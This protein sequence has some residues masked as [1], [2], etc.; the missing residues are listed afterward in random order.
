MD[1]RAARYIDKWVGLAICAVLFYY[2]RVIGW[3]RGHPV[4]RR[5][6][7]TPPPLENASPVRVRRVLCVKF[8]GLGNIVMLLPVI[9]AMKRRHPDAEIDFLTLE[10]NCTLLE[11]SPVVSHV[12]TLSVSGLVPLILSTL[13]VVPA[14]RQRGYDAVVDFEQFAKIS[15][16]LAFLSGAKQ[17]IGF[18][19]DGQR[20]EGLF[21]TRVVYTDSEHMAHIFHRL[22]R[23]LDVPPELPHAEI[24]L[25]DAEEAV[26]AD[27]IRAFGT[28]RP[29]VAMHV[30]CGPNFYRVPLKRWEPSS[31]AAVADGLI[32]RYG[33][34]VVLTGAGA[35]ERELIAEV[36]GLMRH[37]AVD[38][39]NRFSVPELMAFLRQSTFLVANDT[40]LVHLAAAMGTPCVAMFG[41]TAPLHYGPGGPIDLV[42]YRD[43]YCSPCLTNYN[44]KISRCV[45]PVCMRGITPADVLA[46]IDAHYLGRDATHGARVRGRIATSD[47][48]AAAT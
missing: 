37:D 2:A 12:H 33:A 42:F 1:L 32:E 34:V 35:E 41:P 4:P 18:N 39:C 40:A 43:L 28:G 36:R 25:T 5:R 44:L 30:G 21:T 9:Q 8:Y 14:L 31:F 26:A 13:R 3:L 23:P 48:R 7:T 24:H 38:A 17:R 16:I 27:A 10:G 11:R 20:R 15:P 45:D 46:A 47:D 29:I 22:T 19:T 6:A